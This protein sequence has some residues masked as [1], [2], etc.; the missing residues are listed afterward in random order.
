MSET[1][2]LIQNSTGQLS[3]GIAQGG[4][5]MFDS[6]ACAG[7]A[8]NRAPQ[9][10]L[11]AGLA[12]L[13]VPVQ[14]VTRIF[15]DIG[16]GGL[17]ATRSSV[18]FANALGFGLSCPV[19]GLPAFALIGHGAAR[20][21]G[22]PVLCIRPAARPH[23]HLA[24]YAEGRLGALRFVDLQAL[25]KIV[26]ENLQSHVFAGKFSLPEGDEMPDLLPNVAAM[27]DIWAVAQNMSSESRRAY[28]LTEA[29][30]P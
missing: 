10:H 25:R 28:P 26:A 14:A 21:A 8:Q 15:V 30:G 1:S 7:L 9:D 27:A 19:I 16:P 23:F 12:V 24:E 22:R 18:A 6:S 11:R 3:L 4:A 13:D 2:L 29:I 20:R 17:G 5:L